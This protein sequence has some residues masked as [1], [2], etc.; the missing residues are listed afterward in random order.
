MAAGFLGIIAAILTIV[1]I[2]DTGLATIW[3]IVYAVIVG[4]FV[5]LV[6]RIVLAYV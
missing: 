6:S 1:L 4:G 5:G 2:P 3:R